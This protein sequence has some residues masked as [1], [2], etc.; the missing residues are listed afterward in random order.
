MSQ[1]LVMAAMFALS[2][3]VLY[4]NM[5]FGL[6]DDNPFEERLEEVVKD[7]LGEDVDLT[8]GSSED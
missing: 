5:Q 7:I 1:Y 3:A 6:P 8:P 4:A 2:L